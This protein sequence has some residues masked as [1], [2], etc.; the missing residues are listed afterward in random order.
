M[1]WCGDDIG[2][3]TL[4]YRDMC[5]SIYNI[6]V[7]YD[8]KIYTKGIKMLQK[9]KI[10]G[11][12]HKT[13]LLKGRKGCLFYARLPSAPPMVT[14]SKLEIQTGITRSPLGAVEKFPRYSE[15]WIKQ[16]VVQ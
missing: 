4:W 15:L 16:K 13:T 14:F 12:A 1:I 9:A 2:V 5:A 11:I 3:K 10:F 8:N 6:N 7:T